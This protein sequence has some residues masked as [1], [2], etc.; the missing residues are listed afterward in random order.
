MDND[1]ALEKLI[2]DAVSKE[3]ELQK[4]E[5]S[6]ALQ[7]KEFAEMMVARRRQDDELQVLWSMVRD[8]MEENN[9]TEHSNDY[10]EL[11]LTPSGKYRLVE[12][13]DIE[14]VPD[15][16]C[17]VKKSLDNKKIKAFVS[18]NG[19]LPNGVEST[20]NVLRKKFLVSEQ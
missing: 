9:I 12:G 19:K 13:S 3:R 6:L 20:G 17:V 1:K 4:K 11:K 15:E 7:N 18:L 8:Y 2:N 16:V 5:E 10:I 14:D